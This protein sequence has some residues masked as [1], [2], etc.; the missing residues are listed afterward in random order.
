M[1][2]QTDNE[3]KGA[4]TV[5][6]PSNQPTDQYDSAHGSYDGDPGAKPAGHGSQTSDVQ[7]TFSTRGK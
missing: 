1:A 2:E 5:S 3:K 4:A 6:N 7:S